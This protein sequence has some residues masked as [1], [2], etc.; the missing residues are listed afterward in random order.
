MC[1]PTILK[2][3]APWSDRADPAKLRNYPNQRSPSNFSNPTDESACQRNA[4]TMP[5]SSESWL[6]NINRRIEMGNDVE[7][8]PSPDYLK[9]KKLLVL[10]S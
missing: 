1:Q 5:Y 10:K 9:E 7:Y 4:A 6:G 8:R 2:K 3:P